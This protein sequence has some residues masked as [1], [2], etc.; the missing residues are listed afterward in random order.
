MTDKMNFLD[1]Y[2]EGQPRYSFEIFPPKDETGVASLLTA[3]KDLAVFD[4][5]FVSVTYGAMGSTR[6]LTRDLALRI[7]RELN[8]ATAF[9]LAWWG[10]RQATALVAHQGREHFVAGIQH[11]HAATGQAFTLLGVEQHAPAIR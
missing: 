7:H 3:L 9:H 11:A 10:L 2:K 1:F 8:L 5:A 6:D 4:P